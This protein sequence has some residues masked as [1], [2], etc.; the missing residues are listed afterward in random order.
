MTRTSKQED[1]FFR[2]FDGVEIVEVQQDPLDRFRTDM[3]RYLA[4]ICKCGAVVRDDRATCPDCDKTLEDG[5][6][7]KTFKGNGLFNG[8]VGKIGATR[9]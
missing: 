5:K 1:D 3:S 8:G 4:K 6:N 9:S 7:A 2:Y